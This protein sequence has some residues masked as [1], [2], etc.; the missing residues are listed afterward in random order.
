MINQVDQD[1]IYGEFEGL[2]AFLNRYVEYE[3]RIVNSRITEDIDAFSKLFMKYQP[4]DKELVEILSATA[5]Y[6]N[7]FNVLNVRRYETKL[8]TPFLRHLLDPNENH[9]QGALF[10]DSFLKLFTDCNDDAEPISNRSV[11][12]EVPADEGRMDL[13]MEYTQGNRRKIVV[14][15]N[16]IY[17]ADQDKQLERYYQYITARK[18]TKGNFCI[19]YLK[20]YRGMPSEVSLPKASYNQLTRE[21]SLFSIGYHEDIAAWLMSLLP[22]IK[23]PQLHQVIV[24]Y[25]ETI[26]SL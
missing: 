23:P 22:V 13:I 5:P 21:K 19:L 3:E 14:I 2:K 1:N 25:I 4:V 16:K 6:Y 7:I 26:K 9:Q 17:A 20:P 12:E 8:H 18:F 11:K 15:E 24:Q 10:Y